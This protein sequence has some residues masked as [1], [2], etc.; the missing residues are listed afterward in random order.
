MPAI[1]SDNSLYTLADPFRQALSEVF[2]ETFGSPSN[3]SMSSEAATN[4]P[5]AEPMCFTII[6]A[7]GLRGTAS[8]QLKKSEALALAQKLLSETQDSAAEFTAARKQAVEG[9]LRKLMERAA[10]GFAAHFGEV[11]LQLTP[12]D[13]PLSQGAL[14][15]LSSDSPNG[16]LT[17][18]LSLAPEMLASIPATAS[19]TTASSAT[20]ASPSSD[21]NL[22]LLLGVDLNLTLRFGQ[23]T[24]TLR[25]IM[26]L[27]SGSIVELDR[28]VQ[29]P[30]DLLLGDRLIARGEVVIVDGNYGLRITEVSDPQGGIDR[31]SLAAR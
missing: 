21:N 4:S 18:Q 22:D 29:E 14:I 6:A 2:S 10:A 19:E 26:E 17:V 25:E 12:S 5:E 30:A 20:Q 1:N 23:R 27:S 31:M 7:G 8:I 13:T 3:V 15:A 24:L 9:L 28:Q 11:T 16:P